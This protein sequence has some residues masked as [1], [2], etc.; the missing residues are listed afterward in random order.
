MTLRTKFSLIILSAAL[1]FYAGFGAWISTRA[2]QPANDP[3][4]QLRIY[5]NDLQH[6]QNYYVD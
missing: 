3:N 4:A 2:Q 5:D 6:I 1:A